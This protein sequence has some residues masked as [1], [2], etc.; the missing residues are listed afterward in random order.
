RKELHNLSQSKN[1]HLIYKNQLDAILDNA[2]VEIYLK[3]REGRYIKINKQFEK[4]FDVKNEDV[5]GLLPADVH[6]SELATSTRNHDLS[7]LNSGKVE[8]REEVSKVDGDG[9]LHTLL[10]IKFPVFNGD[11]EVDGLGAVVTDI[12]DEATTKVKLMQSNTLFSQAEAMGNMGHFYW[13][14]TKDKLISCSDQFARIYGMTVPEAL[15]CFV[16]IDAVIDL[17]HPDDKER[18]RQ[19]TSFHNERRNGNDIEYR[20]TLSGNTRYL[21]V[22]REILFDNDGEPLQAFGIV[23]DIT[24][25]KQAEEKLKR[26][27]H[28]DALTSLPNRVLLADRLNHAMVQC[29]RRNQSLAVAYMDLDGFK[30][31]N[32]TYGHDLGDKLLV[33]LSKRI[34]KALRE[35]DT[36]ARI[37]GDEFIAI[38]VDLEKVKDSEPVLKRLLK[39]AAEPVTVGD[40]ILQVSLS[41]GVTLYPQNGVD[42]DQLIRHADEAMYVAKHS[43]KNRYHLFDTTLDKKIT[44]QRESID[45]VRSALGGRE[46]VLHYQPKVNMHTSEVIGVEALIR[47]QHPV[48]GLVPPLEFLPA[49]E[50]HA[51]SLALGE[52]VIATALSQISQWRSIGVNLPI[53]VNISGYQLQQRNFAN[54]LAVLL[55][56]RPDVN[57]HYLE[58]EILETSA[59]SDID[60]VSTTIA[61]CHELG[62]RFA[63]D[64]FG[65]GYSSLTHLKRLSAHMIK[66]DQSFVRDMLEDIDDLAIVES[67]IGLAKTFKREVIAEGVETIEHGVAL[68]QLGCELAQGYGIAR[69][70]TAGDIPEW[71]S[72]WKADD[73]WQAKSLIE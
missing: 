8:R 69:P 50:G 26:I 12:S 10:T 59:L 32:D 34:K 15:E 71:I 35:G 33:E 14:L 21:Y 20:V 45:D 55:A 13:D 70:M 37:G 57:S 46:F 73:S 16:N 17:I 64:D 36:L 43:G 49:I 27:A 1:D 39:A 19:G 67:V 65:T 41:I 66:I 11:G 51:I 3:D 5:V 23:Q 28:Y 31:V 6:Y 38:M 47:W 24:E 29:Q 60:Q 9:Q 25:S 54:R 53:S 62:V 52:W 7:V 22:R 30:A 58:L 68:L 40:S 61:A 72:S 18:F 56:A 2:P 48:R 44:I 4:S 42:A 63:L